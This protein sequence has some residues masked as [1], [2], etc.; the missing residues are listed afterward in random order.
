[1]AD[2]LL[3]PS[4]ITGYGLIKRE[5]DSTFYMKRN[6]IRWQRKKRYE[7]EDKASSENIH[8]SRGEGNKK[9]KEN[10]N[11]MP[12]Q[13]LWKMDNKTSLKDYEPL[14]KRSPKSQYLPQN[15]GGIKRSLKI[16]VLCSNHNI[17]NPAEDPT[18]SLRENTKNTFEL[19][20]CIIILLYL[21]I[22]LWLQVTYSLRLQTVLSSTST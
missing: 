4:L 20:I 11:K 21:E 7:E 14:P 3:F 13:F 19:I 8:K 22:Y 1:M 18:I 10:H 2:L 17:H 5:S 16:L 9:K 15:W 6:I 12:S